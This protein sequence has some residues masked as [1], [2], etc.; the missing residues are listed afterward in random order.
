MGLFETLS[1]LGLARRP[2][3]VAAV[4][5]GSDSTA[6]LLLLKAYLDHAAP[7]TRLLAVT[8][9]HRLRPE[10]AAEARAVGRLAAAHRIDHRIMSWTG[11]KPA[12]GIAA[13][14]REARYRLL[15]HAARDAGADVILTAHTADDQAETVFMRRQRG[16]GH[17]L[18]GMAP[19]TLLDGAVWLLRPLLTTSRAALR[20]FLR[21]QGV[22]WIDD[23]GNTDR[24]SER[25][26]ARF[27][28]AEDPDATGDVASLL[29]VARQ[30]AM[31]RHDLGSRAAHLVRGYARRAEPG[32]I[33]IDPTFLRHADRDA[34]L[35]ALRILLAVTGGSS[36]LLDEARTRALMLRLAASP[37]R[38]TLSRTLVTSRRDGIWLCREQRTLPAP[39]PARDGMVWDGRFRISAT[40]AAPAAEIAPRG[41]AGAGEIDAA[42]DVPRSM[43]RT[44]SAT[45]PVFSGGDTRPVGW[46]VTPLL[47]P[48]A[49]FLPC[50]DLEP[51]RAVAEL[52]AAPS[53]P[54]PPCAGHN[55]ER[56]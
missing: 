3:I 46:T 49:G 4:S 25:I 19:A 1:S 29:E 27:H 52:F 20:S 45:M 32:L 9:D 38:A 12:T 36:H 54:E 42:A 44:A 8:V 15:V 24:R 14:A 7:A 37:C 31:Q 55:V 35:H 41:I 18:A 16:E 56:A 39:Q 33:R 21:E 50:F 6:L 40:A 13:A 17:G 34:I 26:R 51:A 23:P 22:D 30:A 5:G 43:V 47:A 11:P 48:W 28:L 53:I 10:A 2:V